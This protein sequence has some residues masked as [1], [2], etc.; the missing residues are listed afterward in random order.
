MTTN[1]GKTKIGV[2]IRRDLEITRGKWLAQVAHA[3]FR[4]VGGR[5]ASFDLS[6]SRYDESEEGG[7][8]LPVAVTL[9]VKN[10]AGLQKVIAKCKEAG[11]GYGLQVDSGHNEVAKGTPTCLVVGPTSEELFAIVCKGLQVLKD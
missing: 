5:G 2:I 8:G 7:G 1:K 3:C 10:E 4:A 9:Y 6:R 11:V